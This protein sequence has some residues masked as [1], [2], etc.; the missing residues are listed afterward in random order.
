MSRFRRKMSKRRSRREFSRK[1][2]RI[3][4]KNTSTNIM[5]G[6]IRL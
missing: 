2:S 6:G 5:R 4:K 1:A 3:H